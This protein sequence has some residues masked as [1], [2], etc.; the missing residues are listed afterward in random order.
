VEREELSLDLPV[1]I[2]PRTAAG[3]WGIVM[4]VASGGNGDTQWF[5]YK[6]G[7]NSKSMRVTWDK[8]SM[9]ATAPGDLADALIRN[10]YARVMTREEAHHYNAATGKQ[11]I[12]P[13]PTMS[14]RDIPQV[15]QLPIEEIE[16]ELE[17]QQGEPEREPPVD[18]QPEEAEDEDQGDDTLG[19]KPD[20][21]DKP[22]PQRVKRRN[23]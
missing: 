4:A 5:D 19:E 17:Q 23:R 8:G 11:V 15:P 7:F 6:P 10:G 3:N 21:D 12:E 13:K 14:E 22:K 20:A 16:K 1:G 18:E 9:L 2:A